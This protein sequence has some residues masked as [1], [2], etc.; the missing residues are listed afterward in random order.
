MNKKEAKWMLNSDK[1]K[2]KCVMAIVVEAKFQK[3][4]MWLLVMSGDY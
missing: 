1:I 3:L 2:L 4:V